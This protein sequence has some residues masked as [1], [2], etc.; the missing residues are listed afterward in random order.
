MSEAMTQHST[1]R[2]RSVAFCGLSF[3]QYGHPADDI[4]AHLI[5]QSL[6]GFQRFSGADYIIHDQDPLS[7]QQIGFMLTDT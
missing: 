7:T 6:N 3:R 5:Y 4:A 2:A 1:A